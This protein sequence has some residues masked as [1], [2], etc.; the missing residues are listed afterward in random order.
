MVIGSGAVV[1][2]VHVLDVIPKFLAKNFMIIGA[3]IGVSKIK[4]QL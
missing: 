4:M 1:R 3:K 2:K